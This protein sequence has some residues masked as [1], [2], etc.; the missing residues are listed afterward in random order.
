MTSTTLATIESHCFNLWG[1]RLFP[2]GNE[3]HG[4]CPFCGQA[5]T[6]GFMVWPEGNYYCRKCDRRGRVPGLGETDPSAVSQAKLV[7]R[8]RQAR[9][10][11]EW[12]H[13]FKAGYIKGWH[14]A[15]LAQHLAHWL[16]RGITTENVQRYML[17]YVPDRVFEGKDH[18]PFHS[19]AYT[20]P[21]THPLTGELTNCQYRLMHLPVGENGKYRQEPGLPPASFF[22]KRTLGGPAVV[23]EGGVKA[24]VIRQLLQAKLQVVGLPGIQP[25]EALLEQLSQFDLL[26]WVMDPGPNRA[27]SYARAR[28]LLG[29]RVKYVELPV[30]PDDGVVEY[31]MD[32]TSFK[33]YLLQA[34]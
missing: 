15:M 28:G 8:Q 25:A 5:K 19:D 26:W 18:A 13:G 29:Q 6:D 1:I 32:L 16:Q 24:I 17:G 30:K 12:Q 22:T 14:E 27:D 23:V 3:L 33:A 21:H 9:A 34:R 31:G 11:T 10:L 2:K 7:K 20:I 4:P